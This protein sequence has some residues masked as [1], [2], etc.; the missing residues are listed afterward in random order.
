MLLA[1][2][3]YTILGRLIVK[4]DDEHGKVAEVLR[5]TDIKGKASVSLYVLAIGCAFWLW[6]VSD[7]LIAIVAIIWLI[8]D[9][10]IQ[11]AL[12]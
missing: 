4:S 8:P 7:A 9:K 5:R 12:D 1:G 3:A 6:W 2:I 10:R 11:E